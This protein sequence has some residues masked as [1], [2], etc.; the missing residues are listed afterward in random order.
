MEYTGEETLE[1]WGRSGKKTFVWCH[2]MLI[3]TETETEFI[4]D[5]FTHDANS[6][7]F[8][9][10]KTIN[11]LQTN[12]N[13][14]IQ[15]VTPSI[16]EYRIW[17]NEFPN[18]LMQ[19]QI[20]DGLIQIKQ[21]FKGVKIR[22]TLRFANT[23]Y[24]MVKRLSDWIRE[25]R[26]NGLSVIVGPILVTHSI[27]P[28][29]NITEEMRR[30][31]MR[32]DSLLLRKIWATLVS[33]SRGV[34]SGKPLFLSD[35]SGRDYNA[36]SVSECFSSDQLFLF[37]KIV[38]TSMLMLSQDPI[39]GVLKSKLDVAF[40]P[41][42]YIFKL[43]LQKQDTFSKSLALE[44]TLMKYG[45]EVSVF[46]RIDETVKELC[47]EFK[48]TKL[49]LRN[50]Q[51][52]L[53][54]VS[55]QS[56]V[57]T[58][59][60]WNVVEEMQ[61]S[62]T[63]GK[64]VKNII[65]GVE[66]FMKLQSVQKDAS[67]ETHRNAEF[68]LHKL[69]QSGIDLDYVI[70]EL[71]MDILKYSKFSISF[72]NAF[73]ILTKLEKNFEGTDLLLVLEKT[74]LFCV[75]SSSYEESEHLSKQQMSRDGMQTNE[76]QEIEGVLARLS[77]EIKWIT[78]QLELKQELISKSDIDYASKRHELSQMLRKT[79]SLKKHFEKDLEFAKGN[80]AK[81]ELNQLLCFSSKLKCE[82]AK[83]NNHKETPKHPPIHSEFRIPLPN[84]NS[85]ISAYLDL[86]SSAR[87]DTAK[88][89]SEFATNTQLIE[90]KLTL[91]TKV[92]FLDTFR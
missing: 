57:T 32:E 13:K 19:D 3:T 5:H 66:S 45:T 86:I 26:G 2:I 83:D 38:E 4:S 28:P 50:V 67:I 91:I 58:D 43:E 70:R 90:E 61:Q 85:N 29:S 12:N 82:I 18:A 11:E 9:F 16:I 8:N 7:Q 10:M 78:K 79:N 37:H 73:E 71:N 44:P 52:V 72:K 46:H 80:T 81:G 77:K 56:R 42:C 48:K 22:L 14:Y 27:E 59:T 15:T 84:I 24:M 33:V 25:L 76:I 65:K 69:N 54:T 64:G 20:T 17:I 34:S 21:F 31:R 40:P 87:D 55:E 60:L 49:Y 1:F 68:E 92:L 74:N 36:D 23:A 41:F 39:G 63:N 6:T 35:Y 75:L 88:R 62:Y 51:L 89:I 53:N 30:D 47:I